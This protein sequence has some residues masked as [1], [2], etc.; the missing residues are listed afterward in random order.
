MG[1]RGAHGQPSHGRLPLH[2]KVR[3]WVDAVLTGSP[4]TA[5]R[6]QLEETRATI[7]QAERELLEATNM[8]IPMTWGIS[9]ELEQ[10]DRDTMMSNH[11]LDPNAPNFTDGTPSAAM[12]EGSAEAPQQEAGM[13]WQN[14]Q[15][16]RKRDVADAPSAG[17][18]KTPSPM[19]RKPRLPPIAAMLP[20]AES[21]PPAPPLS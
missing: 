11:P 12:T 4:H 18:T 13:D 1:G 10:L 17:A 7:S 6:L 5:S 3:R 15:N 8:R 9:K 2:G 20:S 16:K 19:R 14:D 21:A